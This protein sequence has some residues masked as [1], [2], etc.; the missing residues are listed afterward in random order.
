MG[1][2][3]QPQVRLDPVDAIF[4]LGVQRQFVGVVIGNAVL[5]P[6]II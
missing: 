5:F 6:A 2:L 4:A 1:H 3:V